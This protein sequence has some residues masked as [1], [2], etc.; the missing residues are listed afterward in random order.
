[1][2]EKQEI[3]FVI[4]WVDDTDSEWQ[5]EKAK[6]TSELHTDDKIERYR[7]WDLLKY[8]CRGVETYSP[9][10]R[11]IHFVT[12][13]HVPEWL[14][15]E[16]PKIHV[17]EHEDYIPTE[18]LPTFNS[19]VIEI[20][21][22][23]IND[24]ADRFVYFNDDMFLNAITEPTAFFVDGKP[25]DILAF[26]PVVANPTNPV[27]SHL[28]MNN[29]LVLSK[30]F[31]KREN[32]KKQPSK[33]FNIKYPALYFGYNFLELTF[34]RYTGFFSAH[35]PMPFLKSTFEKLWELEESAFKEM[36][37]HRFRSKDDLTPYLFREWQKLTGEFCPKN[38][39]R[40]FAYFEISDDTE[41]LTNT[42]VKQKKKIICINDVGNDFEYKKVKKELHNAFDKVLAEV[43]SFERESGK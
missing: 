8:W 35:G 27:M 6:Y 43:S 41:K 32:I 9:W 17:V 25:C 15:T 13:G 1:M 36:S 38:I 22:H 12:C 42:I 23:R 40:D 5:K 18:Y 26:Q 34:P 39:L 31:H 11:K 29:S 14:N 10:A 37:N 20:Y 33:Y 19:N 3:D 7:N 30:Y 2:K 24:L 21:L 16:H 28:Y 4:T